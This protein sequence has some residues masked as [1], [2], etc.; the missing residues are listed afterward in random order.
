VVPILL[1]VWAGGSQGRAHPS[2][3][4]GLAA[5]PVGRRSRGAAVS[6][7]RAPHVAPSALPPRA[8]DWLGLPSRSGTRRRPDRSH[9]SETK[10]R[11]WQ[12]ECSPAHGRAAR[13]RVGLAYRRTPEVHICHPERKLT[14]EMGRRLELGL[15]PNYFP[16][17]LSA[18]CR[19]LM[20]GKI[21]TSEVW[22]V[23]CDA[24]SSLGRNPLSSWN[25]SAGPPTAQRRFW[26]LSACQ[27]RDADVM[28]TSAASFLKT[29]FL[30]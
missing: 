23:G 11:H 25:E 9:P 4:T 17:G 8:G 19:R 7:R 10:G 26:P 2:A 12:T 18:Q 21:Q 5:P 6:R 16:S 3:W 1:Q 30:F 15:K 20:E 28:L 13:P 24:W 29:P 27:P 14:R 22:S